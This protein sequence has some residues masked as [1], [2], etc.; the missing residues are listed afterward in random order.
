MTH[1][2]NGLEDGNQLGCLNTENCYLERNHHVW[3]VFVEP[4]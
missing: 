1:R 3:S 4:V 2:E